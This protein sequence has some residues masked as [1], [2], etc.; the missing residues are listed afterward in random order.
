[1]SDDIQHK[2]DIDPFAMANDE[3]DVA[4]ESSGKILPGDVLIGSFIGFDE[5]HRPLVQYQFDQVTDKPAS[6]PAVSTINLQQQHVGMQVALM[7]VN[8]DIRQPIVM[9]IVRS[10][11]MNLLDNIKVAQP[12]MSTPVELEQQ[13]HEEVNPPMQEQLQEQVLVD[14]KQVTIEAQEN[15][16]L[17]CGESSIT[18]TKSGKIMIRGNYLLNRSTGVNRILGGSVQVN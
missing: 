16:V 7:F 15:I 3:E 6:I 11:L 10:T 1:M 4:L 17:R 9:G 8:Q 5:H 13:R 14:G 18:L 12:E 2:D